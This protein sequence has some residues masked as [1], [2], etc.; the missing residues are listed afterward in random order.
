MAS[1]NFGFEG[2]EEEIAAQQWLPSSFHQFRKLNVIDCYE[3]WTVV[4][5]VTIVFCALRSNGSNFTIYS[6]YSVIG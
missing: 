2:L 6:V 3:V 5:L 4:I 1:Q